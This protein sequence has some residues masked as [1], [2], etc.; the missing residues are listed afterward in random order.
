MKLSWF[1]IGFCSFGA[2]DMFVKG[3]IGFGLINT[4]LVLLNLWVAKQKE[5][6]Q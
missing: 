4:A 6:L 5:N 3:H 2:M 1:A